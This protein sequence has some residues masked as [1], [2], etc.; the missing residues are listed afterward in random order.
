[1]GGYIFVPAHSSSSSFFR[2]VVTL[3][4]GTF[5]PDSFLFFHG[6]LTFP[7]PVH[8]LPQKNRYHG[9]SFLG[10]HLIC[11]FFENYRSNIVA[12]QEKKQNV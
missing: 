11:L 12:K 6:V 7:S 10:L 9:R 4:D 5:G 2:L 8:S 1:M 3:A